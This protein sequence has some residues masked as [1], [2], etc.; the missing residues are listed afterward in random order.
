[1]KKTD[2]GK[3]SLETTIRKVAAETQKAKLKKRT[4]VHE[5]PFETPIE[6][7]GR[8]SEISITVTDSDGE[9]TPTRG[10]PEAQPLNPSPSGGLKPSAEVFINKEDRP[11]EQV[12]PAT[13]GLKGHLFDLDNVF[14]SKYTNNI[15]ILRFSVSNRSPV[16]VQITLDLI[17]GLMRLQ[18]EKA[19]RPT[20]MTKEG[21][22]LFSFHP[23]IFIEGLLT[24]HHG[25]KGVHWDSDKETDR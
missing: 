18:E 3:S 11:K 6:L 9:G 7:E 10:G 20:V 22:T 24:L 25:E 4:S 19:E 17:N 23:L 15:G 5:L 12:L 13:L 21:K 8:K 1:M 16:G 2:S 14:I